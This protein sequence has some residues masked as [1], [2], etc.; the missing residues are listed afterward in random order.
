MAFL[1]RFGDFS[2]PILDPA[3]IET[4]GPD[5]WPFTIWQWSDREPRLSN[6]RPGRAAL[7]AA[8]ASIAG[9]IIN[10]VG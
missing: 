7:S 4:R 10:A 6:M 2:Q 8:A 9:A 3:L 5:E 1:L